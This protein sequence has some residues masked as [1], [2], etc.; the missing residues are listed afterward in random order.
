MKCSPA[1]GM[2]KQITKNIFTCTFKISLD[3]INSC[4]FLVSLCRDNDFFLIVLAVFSNEI[5]D[6]T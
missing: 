6:S 2:V 5:L 1:F 4:S 3:S